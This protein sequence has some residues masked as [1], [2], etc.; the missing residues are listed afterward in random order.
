M[1]TIIK[2]LTLIL[3]STSTILASTWDDCIDRYNKAKEFSDNTQLMYIYLKST[4]MCLTRF[5]KSLELNPDPEFTVEAMSNNIQKLEGYIEKTLPTYNFPNHTLKQ[6]PKYLNADTT[7]IFNQEYNYFKKF[8]H[9]NGIH[10]GDKIYTAKHYNIKDA[11]NLHF[12]LSILP[13]KTTSN[14]E[15]AKL[16]LNKKGTFKYYS[17]SK[18]GMFFG[19]LLQEDNCKFYKE[20]NIPK[21]INTSL[22]LSDLEKEFEIRSSCLAIPSNSGGG[23]F[24]DGKLVGVISKTVFLKESERNKNKDQFLYSIIEPIVPISE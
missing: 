24:Q 8:K 17:M 10:A 15:V 13:T 3:L 16:D 4:K 6:I 23:V 18:I 14:L 7:P 5:K 21:G 19:T 2:G 12:D 22:D 1:K 9:C 11:T 20:K